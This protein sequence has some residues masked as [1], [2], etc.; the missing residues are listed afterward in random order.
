MNSAAH[1]LG[2]VEFA[3]VLEIVAGYASS[4]LGGARVRALVP[5]EAA[6]EVASE[7]GRVEAMRAMLEGDAGWNAE[8][9]PELEAALTRLAVPGTS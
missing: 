1:A 6:G 9:I 3:G 2:I 7:H 8:P 4:P 5:G